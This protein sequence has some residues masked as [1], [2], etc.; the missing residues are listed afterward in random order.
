MFQF[1]LFSQ[2]TDFI[3][4]QWKEHE[5]CKSEST[6]GGNTVGAGRTETA[7]PGTE[8]CW[9][10][11]GLY[12]PWESDLPHHLNGNGL[13]APG[14]PSLAVRRAEIRR[15]AEA[16]KQANRKFRKQGRRFQV[17]V[18]SIGGPRLTK[19]LVRQSLS[20]LSVRWGVSGMTGNPQGHG[21][22]AS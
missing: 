20:F 4:V 17:L 19:T 18:H 7:P 1:Q 11:W 12:G 13:S 5:I 14:N 16:S 15:A 8:Q 6:I 3:R 10:H 22:N 9:W 21:V 2:F